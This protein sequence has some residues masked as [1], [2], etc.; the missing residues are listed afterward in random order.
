KARLSSIQGVSLAEQRFTASYAGHDVHL[1]NL[2]ATIPG[3]SDRQ[4]ALIAPRDVAYGTGAMTS[5]AATALLL[6][7]ASSFSGSTH[8]KPLA[9]VSPDGSSIGA[10]GARRFVRDYPQAGLLDAAIVLSQPAVRRPKAPLVVPW[11]TGPQNTASQLADTA[12][13]IVSK[14]MGTPAGDEGPL[15]DRFR[16]ALPAAP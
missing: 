7:I 8:E 14:E 11:S 2:I 5:N 10:L 13:S 9:F 15:S 3:E 12:N 4:I 1:R 6:E 16:L